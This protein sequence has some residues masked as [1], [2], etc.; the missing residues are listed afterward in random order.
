MYQPSDLFSK[1]YS[2]CKKTYD[3]VTIL[4]AKYGLLLPDDEIEPY[5]LT[6]NNMRIKEVKE[7]SSIVFS[8][9]YNRLDL[10]EIVE[11]NFHTGKK[12]RENLIQKLERIGLKCKT[13][14]ANLSIGNQ[15]V[16]YKK[17][18]N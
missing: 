15:L 12:Y 2:Y 14:L 4:S 17:K 10:D 8:Q 9:M 13:P 1:A 16:W 11:I 3:Q 7:W 18:I 5:D 6:L